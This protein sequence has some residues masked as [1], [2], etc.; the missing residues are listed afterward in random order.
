MQQALKWAVPVAFIAHGLG[1]IGGIY[2]VFATKSWFGGLFGDALLVA[3]ILTALLWVVS[4]V[5]FVAAGWGYWHQLEWWRTAAWVAAPTSIVGIA[6]WAGPIPVGTYVGGLMA[7]ATL[8]AL[9]L[10]W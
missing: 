9:A 8:V 2:F 6:L 3:R 4:G 5:A 10:G 7:A 1:M